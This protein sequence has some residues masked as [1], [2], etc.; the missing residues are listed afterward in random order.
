MDDP[1]DLD[2]S[3]VRQQELTAEGDRVRAAKTACRAH[4]ERRRARRDRPTG[5]DPT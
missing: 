3:R 5:S 2:L 4:R 1:Y